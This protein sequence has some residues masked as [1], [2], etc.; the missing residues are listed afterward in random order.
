MMY[1]K[2]GILNEYIQ[3]L[4]FSQNLKFRQNEINNFLQ[5]IGR[6]TP[7]DK[8]LPVDLMDFYNDST[9]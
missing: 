3:D 2:K 6:T 8:G 9:Y 7:Y 4:K 1:Y 5:S